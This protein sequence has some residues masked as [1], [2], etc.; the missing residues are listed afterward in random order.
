MTTPTRQAQILLVEDHALVR[1]G[2]TTLLTNNGHQVVGVDGG[3]EALHQL[4]TQAFDLVLLD[5]M[6]PDLSGQEVMAH[7]REHRIDTTVVV[8]SGTADI[9]AAIG[10]LQLGA[11]DFLRKTCSTE[12]LLKTISNALHHRWL[13]QDHARI[14]GELEASVKIHRYLIDSSPDIIYTLDDQ[15]C[16]TFI[17]DRVLPLLGWTAQEVIGQHCSVLIHPNDLERAQYVLRQTSSNFQVTRNVELQMKS[18][19]ADSDTRLFSHELMRIALPATPANPS[20]TLEPGWGTYGIAHDMTERK[21]TDALIAHHAFHDVLTELPNRAL[22]KDR[23]ALALLHAQRHQGALAVLVLD[24]D[25]FK[26]VNDTLGHDAGDALLLQIA[27]RLK[28][29]LRTG[30]TLARLGGDEFTVILPELNTAQEATSIADK[31]LGSLRQL[32][33][34]NGKN[35]HLSASIGVAMHPQHGNNPDDLIKNADTAMYHQKSNGKDGWCLF[36][37]NML[38][39]ATEHM[40]LAH[41]LRLALAWGELEMVYQPQVDVQTQKITGVEALMRWNHPQRGL[42][43]PGEFLPYAE[44]SGLIVAMTDWALKAVCKDLQAINRIPGALLRMSINLSPQY[45]DRGNFGG[46]LKDALQRYGL[47]PEQFEVEVTEN[48]C[49][50]SPLAAIE[51]LNALRDL[52]VRIAI[53]DFGTGYS[54]LSYLNRLPIHTLKIDR[55]FVMTIHNDLAPPPVVLA[56]IALAKGLKLHLVAEGVETEVQRRCLAQAGCHTI[57]GYFY[58]KPMPQ[59]QLM[60]LLA[61]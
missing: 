11:F 12:E 21:R 53:D 8:I 47:A 43:T 27:A 49:I 58:F 55:S 30:D 23:L 33:S 42:L 5:L 7:M 34:L 17:N 6:L 59:R 40:A 14:S 4:N 45:L 18:R 9:D 41:E 24:I 26:L 31:C 39:L 61:G 37:G 28:V 3:L 36:E 10:A 32:F 50:R 38:S 1:S 2:L 22:F 52:G 19:H 46:N 51:Q 29:S 35:L 56:I 16:F 54:S 20:A 44:E 13:A 25:R 15:G 48:I 60:A 57:Q